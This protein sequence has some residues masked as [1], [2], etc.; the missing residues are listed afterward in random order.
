MCNIFDAKNV[1]VTPIYRLNF[2]V[3]F[4]Q[5]K[6]IVGEVRGEVRGEIRGEKIIG[7]EGGKIIGGEGGAEETR[8]RR[9][10]VSQGHVTPLHRA[11]P[12]VTK[13]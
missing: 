11:A 12:D 6:I 4:Y 5:S 8:S 9:K 1:T 3:Y 2:P 7:G 10:A 13:L